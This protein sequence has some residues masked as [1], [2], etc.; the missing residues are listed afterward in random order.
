MVLLKLESGSFESPN[1]DLLKRVTQAWR[2]KTSLKGSVNVLKCAQPGL[3]HLVKVESG[4][5]ERPR[6]LASEVKNWSNAQ[7]D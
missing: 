7:S 6:F 4:P 3:A 2:V 1:S 5:S